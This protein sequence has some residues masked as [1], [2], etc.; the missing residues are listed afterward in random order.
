MATRTESNG[1][2]PNIAKA[3]GQHD[4]DF[5]DIMGVRP[6]VAPKA[7]WDTECPDGTVR[8][9]AYEL[10]VALLFGKITPGRGKKSPGGKRA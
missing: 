3:E 6:A 1:Q 10:W 8:G 4:R 9:R 5:C 2:E 7:M